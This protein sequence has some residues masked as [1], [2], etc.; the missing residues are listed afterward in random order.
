[1]NTKEWT[2]WTCMWEEPKIYLERIVLLNELINAERI[3][4]L[5]EHIVVESYGPNIIFLYDKKPSTY[6]ST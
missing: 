4:G 3:I 1:M 5:R 6:K 2:I